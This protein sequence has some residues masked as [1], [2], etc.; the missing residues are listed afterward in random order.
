MTNREVWG[1]I[2]EILIDIEEY[3]KC[4]QAIQRN[5]LR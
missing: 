5:E 3:K 4:R 1:R 2:E